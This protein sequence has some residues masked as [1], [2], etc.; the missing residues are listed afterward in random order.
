MVE[1]SP[2]YRTAAR[3]VPAEALDMRELTDARQ[4]A[5]GSA[6]AEAWRW[7]DQRGDYSGELTARLADYE[8]RPAEYRATVRDA[9][10]ESDLLAVAAAKAGIEV[11]ERAIAELTSKTVRAEMERD[12]AHGEYRALWDAYLTARRQLT[13]GYYDHELRGPR[14]TPAQLRAE[15]RRLVGV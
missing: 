10:P 9:T 5:P 2:K 7:Y 4:A 13:Q 14:R 1:L 15:I 8:R 6:V 11:L 12:I 3:G